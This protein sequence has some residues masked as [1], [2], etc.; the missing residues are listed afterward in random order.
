MAVYTFPEETAAPCAC[1][2]IASMMHN[3][4]ACLSTC[5][6]ASDRLRDGQQD[7]LSTKGAIGNLFKL[8]VLT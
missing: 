7:G 5:D 4:A 3:A 1:C 6:L 8:L 2:W